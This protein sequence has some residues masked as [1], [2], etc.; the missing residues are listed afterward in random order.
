MSIYYKRN[1]ITPVEEKNTSVS[2]CLYSTTWQIFIKVKL[3]NTAVCC[4]YNKQINCIEQSFWEA[5][6]VS[7]SEE[8]P[9][10]LWKPNVSLD[11]VLGLESNPHIQYLNVS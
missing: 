7:S 10:L 11:P 1:S 5:N 6:C 8:I 9:H 4:S 3:H 2:Y